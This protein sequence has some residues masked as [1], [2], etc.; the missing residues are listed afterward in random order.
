[1]T[2][3]ADLAAKIRAMGPGG[4]AR[5]VG[6]ALIKTAFRGESAAKDNVRTV[7]NVRSGHLARSITGFVRQGSGGPEAVIRAGGRIP[8]VVEPVRY[9]ATHEYGAT[10]LPRNGKYLR[11]PLPPALTGAGVDRYGGPLRTMAPGV[12]RVVRV[13]G[14]GIFLVHIPSGQRWYRL[15][16]KATI[17][18]R[19]F[20]RPAARDAAD[21]FPR[22]LAEALDRA[23]R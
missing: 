21:R 18:A 7:L 1:M 3:A 9:A 17:R 11:W 23:L 14:E 6:V 22:Y 19:P 12:F 8:G 13:Q 20:L 10:I 5:V 4:F 2:T 16:R 15:I